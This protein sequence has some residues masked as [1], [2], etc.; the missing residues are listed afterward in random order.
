[1]EYFYR[2]V[3]TAGVRNR[4]NRRWVARAGQISRI[5]ENG[6]LLAHV[7]ANSESKQRIWINKKC[8]GMVNRITCDVP[9]QVNTCKKSVRAL[10]QQLRLI[11]MN[12]NSSDSIV[13]VNRVSVEMK[14][15]KSI[16]LF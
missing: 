10:I 3:Y 16:T 14:I 9:F 5:E 15:I 4:I 11:D 7:K 2:A 1:M 8:V 12:R 13:M 6:D